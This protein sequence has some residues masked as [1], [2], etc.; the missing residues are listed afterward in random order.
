MGFEYVDGAPPRRP[1]QSRQLHLVLDKL[2]AI[3]PA[4]RHVPPQLELE[5][6]S[7]H[8]VAGFDARLELVRESVGG[9][10]WLDTVE[11]LCEQAAPLLDGTS[12]V[13][14][15]LRDDNVLLGR[16]ETV[17]FVDWNWPIVGAPWI[18]TMC[19]LLSAY[20]DGRDV[21]PLLRE[22]PLTRDVE[23]RAIDSLL[24]VLSSYFDAQIIKP[25]PPSSPHLR[26]HQTWYADAVRDWLT[27]R[28]ARR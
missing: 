10:E 24:A 5:G 8:L 22:H 20:G 17:W 11:Q 18:D 2:A 12:I 26:D 25:V 4:L 16:D 9:S 6:I 3:A 23:P 13:H 1:W 21:E 28:L 19:L 7:E 14:M 27:T 15:D